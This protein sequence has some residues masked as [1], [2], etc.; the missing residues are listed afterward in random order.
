MANCFYFTVPHGEVPS[1]IG[2]YYATRT[3]NTRCSYPCGEPKYDLYVTPS[4]SENEEE[5]LQTREYKYIGQTNSPIWPLRLSDEQVQ[6]VTSNLCLA[7]DIAAL[8]SYEEF[9]SEALN[10]VYGKD[11]TDERELTAIYEPTY[12][13]MAVLLNSKNNP[14]YTVRLSPIHQRPGGI[15]LS[16]CKEESTHYY[17]EFMCSDFYGERKPY[18]YGHHHNLPGFKY[19]LVNLNWLPKDSPIGC[20]VRDLQQHDPQKIKDVRLR[21]ALNNIR[22]LDLKE[23]L[24]EFYNKRGMPIYENPEIEEAYTEGILP[25][26]AAGCNDSYIAYRLGL[27]VDTV[28]SQTDIWREDEVRRNTEYYTHRATIVNLLC[29]GV[30]MVGISMQLNVSAEV[31]TRVMT[32]IVLA[33]GGREWLTDYVSR[34]GVQ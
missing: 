20:L 12:D 3:F 16:P 31:V 27:S 6:E 30:N 13:G 19:I 14:N 33:E 7:D 28:K 17:V 5:L 8:I 25:L 4:D 32:D 15:D 29:E 18:Y 21:A 11:E 23:E 2:K 24:H 10:I 22:H 1:R 26:Y 34:K 9:A